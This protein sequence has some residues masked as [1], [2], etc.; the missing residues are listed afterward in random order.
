MWPIG[1]QSCTWPQGGFGFWQGKKA[2]NFFLISDLGT[3][4][5]YLSQT[6]GTAKFKQLD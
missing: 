2:E 5:I 1:A 3:R 6:L 4:G